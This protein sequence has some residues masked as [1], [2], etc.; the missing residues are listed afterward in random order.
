MGRNHTA[1]KRSKQEGASQ[2]E[3][4]EILPEIANGGKK[5]VIQNKCLIRKDYLKFHYEGQDIINAECEILSGGYPKI[6]KPLISLRTF[7]TPL[8]FQKKNPRPLNRV[9]TPPETS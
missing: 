3:C 6:F 8:M 1:I 7:L 2:E 9:A 4:P 5:K